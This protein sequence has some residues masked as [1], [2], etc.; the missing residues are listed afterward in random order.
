MAI[1]PKKFTKR[2]DKLTDKIPG[3]GLGKELGKGLSDVANAV[4]SALGLGRSE[5]DRRKDRTRE[6]HEALRK[7]DWA[8]IEKTAEV[9]GALGGRGTRH[10]GLALE[11]LW[12]L[13]QR[14]KGYSLPE[15]RQAIAGNGGAEARGGRLPNLDGTPNYTREQWQAARSS[16]GSAPD[17]DSN[18]EA[19]SR[20]RE[21]TSST[22]TESASGAKR[23][24]PS[25]KPEMSKEER[26]RRRR[27]A[28]GDCKSGPRDADGYC[29]KPSRKAESG[30]ADPLRPFADA[31]KKK[32][33]CK[34]GARVDGYCPPK[35]KSERARKETKAERAAKRKLETA[36]TGAVTKS[37]RYVYKNL[38]ALGTV[39]LLA[40]ASLIGAAGVAAYALTKKLLTITAKNWDDMRY[41]LSAAVA[42]ARTE[43]RKQNPQVDWDDPLQAEQVMAPFNQYY[44]E[45]RAIMDKSEA[46]GVKPHLE[47]YF[48][49]RSD[50]AS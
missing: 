45:R 16:S 42:R 33:D 13:A 32:R 11:A 23:K 41:E 7:G 3:L 40:K 38:G 20:R 29:P 24:K 12:V 36:V 6:F 48:D 27:L 9:E 46:M 1:V 17:A 31:P 47:F 43:A 19:P 14:K 28:Q 21:T 10:K 4:G 26:A 39:K 50:Y 22:P 44:K 5:A 35:P 15:I 18:S 34:Y 8:H 25:A 37:A 30:G 49:D 2:L